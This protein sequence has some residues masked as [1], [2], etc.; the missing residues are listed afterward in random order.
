MLLCAAPAATTQARSRRRC[1]LCLKPLRTLDV[2]AR[3]TA[4]WSDM[5]SRAA[6]GQAL[7]HTLLLCLFWAYACAENILWC[8]GVTDTT[9]NFRVESSSAI[10]DYFVLHTSPSYPSDRSAAVLSIPIQAGVT[11]VDMAPLP[12]NL[13]PMT[14]YYYGVES[15]WSNTGRYAK[16]TT[17]PSSNTAAN[18][19]F[20]FASCART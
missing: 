8:G 12:D 17:M 20:A 13:A 10:E 6:Q 11:A 5:S 7:T 4:Y 14:T 16:F 1:L 2:A 19:S 15:D 3:A 9:A 18:F